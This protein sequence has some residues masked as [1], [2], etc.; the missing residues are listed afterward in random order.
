MR[1]AF[2]SPVYIVRTRSR[3]WSNFILGKVPTKNSRGQN[4]DFPNSQPLARP[5]PTTSSQ[6]PVLTELNQCFTVSIQHWQLANKVARS[7][8]DEA[9][10]LEIWP[11]KVARVDQ[12]DS[13][14]KVGLWCPWSF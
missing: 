12:F 11:G 13:G 2:I 10:K 7:G 1:P 6:L 14:P 9:Y 8:T 5:P 3:L 4:S